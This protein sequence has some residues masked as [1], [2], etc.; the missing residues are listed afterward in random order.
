MYDWHP[1]EIARQLSIIEFDLFRKIRPQVRGVTV[2]V[3][4]LRRSF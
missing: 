3:P 1:E 2:A 4:H